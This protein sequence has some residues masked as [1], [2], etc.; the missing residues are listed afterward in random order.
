MEKKI[1][2]RIELY[3]GLQVLE[4]WNWED[5]TRVEEVIKNLDYMDISTGWIDGSYDDE[6][7]LMVRGAE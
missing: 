2:I 5:P 6:R 4:N 1:R 3:G 7:L